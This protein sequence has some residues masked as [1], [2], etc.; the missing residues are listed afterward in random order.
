MRPGDQAEAEAAALASALESIATSA[1]VLASQADD[2]GEGARSS[3]LYR[4]ALESLALRGKIDEA[5]SVSPAQRALVASYSG[6]IDDETRGR[7]FGAAMK[8]GG[9]PCST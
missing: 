9:K 5:G 2:E 3:D 6:R 7:A 1:R 4:L 8:Q